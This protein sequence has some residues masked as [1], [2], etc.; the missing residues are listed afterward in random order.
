MNA[1][2]TE[3]EKSAIPRDIANQPRLMETSRIYDPDARSMAPDAER[4]PASRLTGSASFFFLTFILDHM[5]FRIDC[6]SKNRPDAA[7][8]DTATEVP[9]RHKPVNVLE[10]KKLDSMS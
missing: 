6:D 7:K 5:R 1:I 2:E 4:K 8:T 9:C 3:M 10:E